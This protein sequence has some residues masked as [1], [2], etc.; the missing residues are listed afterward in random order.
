LALLVTLALGSSGGDRPQDSLHAMGEPAEIGTFVVTID[1]VKRVDQVQRKSRK[2]SAPAGA[3]LLV[4]DT[5]VQND[6]DKQVM[7]LTRFSMTDDKQRKF[8]PTPKCQISL[9]NSLGALSSLNP[10]IAKTGEVCFE[11]PE[12]V[13]GLKAQFIAGPLQG[14]A[15][16]ELEI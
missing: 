15:S 3:D 14:Q 5:R 4:L 1:A 9:P 6:G 16:F 11:I 2:Y 7:L 12:G 8:L 13:T 10:G